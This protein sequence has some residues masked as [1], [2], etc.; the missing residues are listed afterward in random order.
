VRCDRQRY[1]ATCENSSTLAEGAPMRSR[2]GFARNTSGIAQVL[3]LIL[4]ASVLQADEP[5]LRFAD[6]CTIPLVH[7]PPGEFDMGRSSRGALLAAALSFGEQGD[8]AAE[9]PVRRVTISKPFYIGKYKINCAQFCRFLNAIDDPERCININQFSYIER[10]DGAYYP[11]V[12]RRRTQ[13]TSFIGMERHTS[14]NG[15]RRTPE[16]RCDCLPRPNG[17]M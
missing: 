1:P 3:V 14:A 5:R 8:W 2:T 7:I 13:S 17:K 4:C 9:G 10:R 12:S 15:S 11:K 16:V 6:D